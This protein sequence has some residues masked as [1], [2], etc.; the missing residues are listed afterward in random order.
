MIILII[1]LLIFILFFPPS[2]ENFNYL[3]YP[4]YVQYQDILEK[5]LK[6]HPYQYSK[7]LNLPIFYNY[8]EPVLP[9]VQ[10]ICNINPVMEYWYTPQ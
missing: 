10:P 6:L 3:S 2:K 5:N 9:F 1:I 4:S 7:E 8:V